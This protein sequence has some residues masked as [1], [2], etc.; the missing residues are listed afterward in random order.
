MSAPNPERIAELARQ[1][2]LI[3]LVGPDFSGHAELQH[4]MEFYGPH[5]AAEY[6]TV[7]SWHGEQR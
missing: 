4:G 6:R 1:R 3:V 2:G 5:A 7:D